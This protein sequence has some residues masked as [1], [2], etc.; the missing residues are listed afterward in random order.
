MEAVMRRTVFSF[1]FLL[2]AGSI[3]AS[4]MGQTWLWVTV[5]KVYP[6]N[7]AKANERKVRLFV[8][9][10]GMGAG[11]GDRYGKTFPG[12]KFT[13]TLK[14][15][16]H[17]VAYSMKPGQRFWVKHRAANWFYNKGGKH[18][19]GRS[20][21][22]EHLGHTIWVHRPQVVMNL[23]KGDRIPKSPKMQYLWAIR[24]GDNVT[25]KLKHETLGKQYTDFLVRNVR[26]TRS[27]VD[28]AVI[29]TLKDKIGSYMTYGRKKSEAV[30]Q[31]YAAAFKGKKI[32]F[33][34]NGKVVA[35]LD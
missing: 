5:E 34:F 10:W 20:S 15:K 8:N 4:W 19:L 18:H 25:L 30:L 27:V 28:L 32:R 24:H 21:T 29:C 14:F 33:I 31:F 12:K 16:D 11:H 3:S 9:Q 17:N 13:V 1:I 35:V 23:I 6:W 22:W 26:E 7:R 2:F